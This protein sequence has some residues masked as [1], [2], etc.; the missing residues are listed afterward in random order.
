MAAVLALTARDVVEDHDPVAG[1]ELRDS[2]AGGSNGSG[3]FMAED[4]RH[5][6][7]S[8][9]DLLQ[10]STANAAGMDLEQDF[11]ATDLGYRNGFEPHVVLAAVDGGSH[12]GRN[13]PLDL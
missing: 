3:G 5:G 4:S 12:R 11:A 8:G 9:S 7:R 2:L 6:V 1:G 13:L 10:V